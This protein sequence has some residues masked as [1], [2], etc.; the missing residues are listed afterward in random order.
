MLRE[1][2]DSFLVTARAEVP[3]FAGERAKIFMITVMVGAFDSCYSFWVISTLKKLFYCF[4]YPY[5]SVLAVLLC[6]VIVVLFFKIRK[7]ILENFLYNILLFWDIYRQKIL[8]EPFALYK[9][10]KWGNYFL[11]SMKKKFE[12]SAEYKK[13][14]QCRPRCAV[15]RKQRLMKQWVVV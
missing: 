10:G 7:V 9:P 3:C 2:E 8:L 12:S 6:I 5:Y 4:F 13:L 15:L 1:E 11:N 14:V